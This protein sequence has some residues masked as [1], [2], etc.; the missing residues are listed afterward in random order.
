MFWRLIFSKESFF[1]VHLDWNPTNIVTSFSRIAILGQIC[2]LHTKL[3]TYIILVRSHKLCCK[4]SISFWSQQ[5]FKHISL[6]TID[7]R[8]CE[9]E[10]QDDEKFHVIFA[11]DGPYTMKYQCD[12]PNTMM[13]GLNTMQL[14]IWYYW[15]ALCF[16]VFKCTNWWFSQWICSL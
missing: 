14:C 7:K 13:P 2:P 4:W 5:S 1:P 16:H 12:G 10:F 6:D 8:P 11:C 3:R 9:H 15:R